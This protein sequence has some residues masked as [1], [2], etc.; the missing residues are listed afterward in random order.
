[1]SCWT[2]E[3]SCSIGYAL[4]VN[5]CERV[6][7]VDACTTTAPNAITAFAVPSPGCFS[8]QSVFSGLVAQRVTSPSESLGLFRTGQFYLANPF[9]RRRPYTTPVAF[10]NAVTRITEFENLAGR[11]RTSARAVCAGVE[12][13]PFRRLPACYLSTPARPKLQ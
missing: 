6:G 5:L 12:S 1:M 10:R 8:Q 4:A 13:S 2:K 3:R 7:S 11:R 9:S